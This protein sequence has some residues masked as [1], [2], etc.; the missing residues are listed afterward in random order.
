MKNQTGTTSK[1]FTISITG[2]NPAKAK[3]ATS[4][5]N[6]TNGTLFSEVLEFTGTVPITCTLMSG[7]LLEGVTFDENTATVSGSE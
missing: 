7:K 3:I 6:A 5:L 2:K 4:K 1:T